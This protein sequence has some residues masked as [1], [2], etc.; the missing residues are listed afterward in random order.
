MS[1]RWYVLQVSLAS[2]RIFVVGSLKLAEKASISESITEAERDVKVLSVHVGV[3]GRLGSK[4]VSFRFVIVC[5]KTTS[6]RQSLL[7]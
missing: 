3:S 4:L 7:L 5:D 1:N 6:S 2:S